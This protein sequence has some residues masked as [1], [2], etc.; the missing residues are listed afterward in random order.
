MKNSPK[1]SVGD[2]TKNKQVVP[3]RIAPTKLDTL[4]HVR[5]ELGAIYRQAK[6]GI[7]STTDLTRYCY[8]LGEIRKIII[9][10]DIETRLSA[11]EARHANH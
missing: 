10:L 5:T 1:L 2:K 6:T 9:D 3:R 7:I 8:A 4:Q 11:L